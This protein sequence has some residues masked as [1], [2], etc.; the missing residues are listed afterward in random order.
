MSTTSFKTVIAACALACLPSLSSAQMAPAALPEMDVAAV[1]QAWNAAPS[2]CRMSVQKALA[3]YDFY[4]GAIDGQLGAAT[5]EG[6]KAYVAAGEELEWNTVTTEGA[7]GL[8][9][10]IGMPEPSCNFPEL[11]TF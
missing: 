1:S 6:I 10:H 11:S 7:M 9:W 5:I 4:A 3:D 2:A 8:L